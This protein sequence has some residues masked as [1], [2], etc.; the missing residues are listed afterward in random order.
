MHLLSA[1]TTL[2]LTLYIVFACLG[3]SA[4]GDSA[5]PSGPSG[6]IGSDG[7]VQTT[8]SFARDIRPLL[9]ARCVTCHYNGSLAVPSFEDPFDP[10]NGIV[11]FEN[12]WFEGHDNDYR[13]VVVP[14]KP[15][16]SFLVYKV[17]TPPD[18]A[19]FDKANNGDPMPLQYPRLTNE[20][21]AAVRQWI[22][23]GAQNDDF[24]RN[25]V[26]PIFGTEKSLG[27][28]GGKC[29]LCHNGEAPT[30][31]NILDVFNEEHGLVNAKSVLSTKLRVR[32]GE[33]DQSFLIEKL[34]NDQPSGGARMP[35]HYPRLNEDEIETIK[36]WIREGAHDN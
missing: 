8:V 3:A 18:P 24:F 34:E 6:A 35:L 12:T 13:Y 26:A 22:S 11:M 10:E 27:R 16:E 21:L 2:S 7:G 17:E 36:T 25:N 32:P 5:S 33:P 15:E 20:E 31:L 28:R 23:D 29:T 30:P 19:T 14:E 1:R 9:Q 4:C